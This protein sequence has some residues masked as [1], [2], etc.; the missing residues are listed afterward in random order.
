M[1]RPDAPSPLPSAHQKALERAVTQLEYRSFATRLADHAGQPLE[2]ILRVLPTSASRT[3]NGIM[4]AAILQC[5]NL[6]IR[7]IGIRREARSAP[8]SGLFL[9]AAGLNGGIGGLLG[10]AALPVELP[11]TTGLMLLA[12]ADTAR[13]YGEDLT[14]LDARLACLEVF[15]LGIPS[16]KNRTDVGYFATRTLLARLAA[17]ASGYFGERGAVGAGAP[18]INSLITEIATRFGLVVSERFAA[19]AVPV[20]GAAGG[21]IVNLLFMNHFQQVAQGHFIIRRLERLY[22]AAT[23]QTEYKALVIEGR[24]GPDAGT[25]VGA[26]SRTSSLSATLKS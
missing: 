2:H 19:S 12:I 25:A 18:A 8:A 14:R 13:Y 22:G 1:K 21:A 16:G 17:D 15:A 20:L 11:L 23:V 6:T 26:V 5:L 10:V 4:E 3:L 9:L 24:R 7:S